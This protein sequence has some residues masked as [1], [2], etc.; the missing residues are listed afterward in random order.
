MTFDDLA[1]LPETLA[2]L[3]QRVAA[4]EKEIARQQANIDQRNQEHRVLQQ[5]VQNAFEKFQENII[6]VVADQ[7][8]SRLKLR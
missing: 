5:D 8:A 1:K 2:V 3:E 4:L 7:L 6:H